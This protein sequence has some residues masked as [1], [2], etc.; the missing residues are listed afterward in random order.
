M[1]ALSQDFGR[2]WQTLRMPRKTGKLTVAQTCMTANFNDTSRDY[3]QESFEQISRRLL[4]VMVRLGRF[5]LPTSCFGG[6]RSIHLSYSRV[7][8]L[9]HALRLARIG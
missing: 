2:E 8:P 5:E 6:T 4:G 9:Y 1:C 3:P 7:R